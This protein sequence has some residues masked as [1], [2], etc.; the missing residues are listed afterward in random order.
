MST[1]IRGLFLNTSKAKCSIY[2]SGKMSY[3]CLVLSNLYKL[4][5]LE[6]NQKNNKIPSGYHF[7]IFNYHITT[8]GWLDLNCIKKIPGF[9]STIVLEVNINNPFSLCPDNIFD[10]YLVLDP[11]LQSTKKYV[12]PFPRPLEKNS[13]PITASE[14]KIPTI[15]SFGF[16]QGDAKGFDKIIEAVNKEFEEAEV[17]INILNPDW[18][19]DG[20]SFAKTVKYL[21]E[22][23][24]KP[25]VKVSITSDYLSKEDL[26]DWCAKN[27][28]NAFFYNR[29]GHGLS[30]TTDQAITSG[31]PI[32]ISTG[33]T[34]RHIHQYVKPYP[35]A[36]L[37]ESINSG[38]AAIKKMQEDWGQENFAK[39]FELVLRE[40]NIFDKK[41]SEEGK[42]ILKI[43]KKVILKNLLKKILTRNVIEKLSN[44]QNNL[45]KILQITRNFLKN[46]EGEQQIIISKNNFIHPSLQSFSDLQEDIF[47]DYLLNNKK[48]GFFI[49]L[50]PEDPVL[51]NDVHRFYQKGWRGLNIIN[52]SQKNRFAKIRIRDENIEINIEQENE[53][54]IKEKIKSFLYN[55]EKIDLLIVSSQYLDILK[56]NDWGKFRPSIIVSKQNND[57]ENTRFFMEGKDYMNLYYNGRNAIFAD[58]FTNNENI[59]KNINWEVLK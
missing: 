38:A 23:P 24:T 25:G 31:R 37:K 56:E 21:K 14:N 57:F 9:K 59:L 43:D 27:T 52:S 22:Y 51:S 4:D 53:D 15:G 32:S 39:K 26:I 10:A 58:K 40:N 18:G 20:R 11:T 2:E 44:A 55:Q 7:Y 12:Y 8:M 16:F 48:E 47:I 34:F 6:I 45:K 33:F 42:I 35:F 1:E 41:A 28:L 3:D 54:A 36:S 49:S 30:A 50:G 46:I 5:Y 19:G 17:K 29:H 13:R